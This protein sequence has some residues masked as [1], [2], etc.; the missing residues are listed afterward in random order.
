M[1]QSNFVQKRKIVQT[2]VRLSS[3]FKNSSNF[4]CSPYFACL[5]DCN[6]TLLALTRSAIKFSQSKPR[7]SIQHLVVE[8]KQSLKSPHRQKVRLVRGEVPADFCLCGKIGRQ[9]LC[10][11]CRVLLL[12]CWLDHYQITIKNIKRSGNIVRECY[13]LSFSE[14]CHQTW[15]Q[16]LH[17]VLTHNR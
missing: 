5:E 6:K 1:F 13:G 8:I 17:I 16:T 2:P 14:Y 10:P 12:H 4:I 3:E 7:E 15:H 9:V 11:S